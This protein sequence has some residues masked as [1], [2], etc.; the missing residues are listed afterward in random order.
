M[1]SISLAL[2]R[3]VE[4][5]LIGLLAALVLLVAAETAAW[6]LWQ[7]SYPQVSEVQGI[8]QVWFAFLAAAYGVRWNFHVGLDLV[9]RRLPRGVRM[10]VERLASLL[11]GVFGA[12]LLRYGLE[13]TRVVEN[14]LPGSG[15]SASVQYVPSW[16]AGALILF[17]ALEQVIRGLPPSSDSLTGGEADV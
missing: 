16:V 17:F 3:A 14:R 8:L 15:L 7:I 13:L 11:V 5:L 1:R 4:L 2:N 12:L 10:V 9:V 6:S